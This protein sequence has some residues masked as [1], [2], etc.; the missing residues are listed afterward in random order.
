MC[1]RITISLVQRV[2]VI[3]FFVLGEA[4]PPSHFILE[5]QRTSN[6][7]QAHTPLVFKNIINQTCTSYLHFSLSFLSHR[8]H[9]W[10]GGKN[11]YEKLDKQASHN[12]R[13][14]L[15]L[16]WSVFDLF[17]HFFLIFLL[18]SLRRPKVMENAKHTSDQPPPAPLPPP[19]MP[20]NNRIY[21]F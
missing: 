19:S 12:Y 10:G 11:L 8:L 21:Y 16:L 1:N 2:N 20:K 4:I 13:L 14:L 5:N 17:K 3:H 7:D 9:L 6:Q 15:L 18:L